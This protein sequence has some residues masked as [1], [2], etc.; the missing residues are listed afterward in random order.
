MYINPF[1]LFELP[2]SSSANRILQNKTAIIEQ[3]KTYAPLDKVQIKGSVVSKQ[4]AL[5]LLEELDNPHSRQHHITINKDRDLFHFLEFGHLNY[6]QKSQDNSPK[7]D[8]AF[9]EFVAPYFAYQYGEALVQA[10]K[11]NDKKSISLLTQKPLSIGNGLEVECYEEAE[12][13]IK[14]TILTLQN[15]R[16][17]SQLSVISERELS[18]YLSNKMIESYNLLPPYFS[19]FRELLARESY[20]LAIAFLENHGR[21]G[22]ATTI[23]KQGLL[24]EIDQTTRQE[25]EKLLQSFSFR[26]KIPTFVWVALAAISA[27]YILKEMETIFYP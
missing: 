10:L 8:A 3:L 27:L 9:W 2:M 16:E 21:S 18:S 24:L 13:Y 11:S 14:K 23:L 12:N 7:K 5:N 15:L 20:Y 25:L 1:Q 22:A 26:S 19:H 17:S 4:K 6:F